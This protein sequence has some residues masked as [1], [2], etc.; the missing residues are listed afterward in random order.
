MN[1]SHPILFANNYKCGAGFL[2]SL[3]CSDI[4]A[5][6]KHYEVPKP[7]YIYISHA[8]S[9][10][11]SKESV[12]FICATAQYILLTHTLAIVNWDFRVIKDLRDLTLNYHIH[13][14]RENNSVCV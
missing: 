9:K 5:Q 7:V 14:S 13:L 1:M 3:Q 10:A 12:P 6:P 2:F 8:N 4:E 11:P